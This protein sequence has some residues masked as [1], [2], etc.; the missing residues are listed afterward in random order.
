MLPT[1]PRSTRRVSVKPGQ[2]TGAERSGALPLFCWNVY[3]FT[4]AGADQ[5]TGFVSFATASAAS[6]VTRASGSRVLTPN[7]VRAF[8]NMF[9]R[10]Y[11]P[12]ITLPICS[13]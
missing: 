12:T 8:T 9:T 11:S 7:G 10:M 3:A 2:R 5:R 4:G 13:M 6:D 1:L